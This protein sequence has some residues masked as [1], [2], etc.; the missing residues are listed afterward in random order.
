MCN[1]FWP[2]LLYFYSVSTFTKEISHLW[3]M[4]PY[5]CSVNILSEILSLSKL[6][7]CLHLFKVLPP[8]YLHIPFCILIM[9]TCSTSF[10]AQLHCRDKSSSLSVHMPL[11]LLSSQSPFS[12]YKFPV[13]LSSSLLCRL[14]HSTLFLPKHPHFN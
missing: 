9:L 5:C 12:N 10:S 14:P 4:K 13:T 3:C 8:P 11:V 7:F 6:T 1:S 2:S